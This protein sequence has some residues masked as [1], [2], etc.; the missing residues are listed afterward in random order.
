MCSRQLYIQVI[1]HIKDHVIVAIYAAD[2]STADVNGA[3]KST[4]YIVEP[5]TLRFIVITYV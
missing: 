3:A 1:M 2:I 5:I 4:V